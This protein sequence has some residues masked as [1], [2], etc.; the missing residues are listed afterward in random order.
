[1]P[2]PPILRDVFH[3]LRD[4]LGVEDDGVTFD[5]GPQPLQR[6][7]VLLYRAGDPA[8]T[9]ALATVG[10]SAHPMPP[11]GKGPGGR[12]E[13]RLFRRGPLERD[14]EQ[15]LA[16]RLANLAAYPWTRGQP[17]GWGE[18]IGFEDEIP[19]F[20]GCRSVFLAGPWAREQRAA[21]ETRVE[22]VRL[23]N[24]VPISPTE[25]AQ[26]RTTRPETFFSGLLDSRDIFAPPGAGHPSPA[27]GAGQG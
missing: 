19:A 8:A 27:P 4:E 6:L 20:P 12:A 11:R 9:T 3:A 25:H 21:L 15:R 17:L 10:M 24:A 16:M 5:D 1:M 22:P 26:A 23:I 2:A 18:L 13:L 14:A 7:D